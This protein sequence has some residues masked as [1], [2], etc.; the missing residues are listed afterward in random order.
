MAK[1]DLTV[2]RLHELLDYDQATGI[3]RWRI[4]RPG[5]SKGKTAGAPHCGGYLQTSVDQSKYLVHRLAWF[6]VHGK[7]PAFQIDHIDGNKRNN[8]IANLRDVPQSINQQN[9]RP[10][11]RINSTGILGVSIDRTRS[12]FTAH[13]TVNGKQ[14]NL[15][16]FNTVE[17]AAAAYRLAKRDLHPDCGR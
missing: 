12:K 13:I 6:Y 11:S 16:R 3:F 7:W 2:E 17:E 8:A 4:G 9:M 1:N 15:G 14:R 5:V 10:I